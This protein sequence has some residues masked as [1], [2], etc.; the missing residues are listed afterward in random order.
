MDER[1]QSGEARGDALVRRRFERL[2]GPT[3]TSRSGWSIRC[4]AGS[5]AIEPMGRAP[6]GSAVWAS[7]T[8]SLIRRAAVCGSDGHQLPPGS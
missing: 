2:R 6:D 1:D 8:A 7:R 4:I 5:D 3:R